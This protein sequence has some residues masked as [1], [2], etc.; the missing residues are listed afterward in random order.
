MRNGPNN[1]VLSDVS[2]QEQAGPVGLA[3]QDHDP[4]AAP[5]QTVQEQEKLPELTAG[6]SDIQQKR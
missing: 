3:E 1:T 4:S 2:L 5:I 6:A